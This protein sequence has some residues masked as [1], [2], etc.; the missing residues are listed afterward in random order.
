MGVIDAILE[1][2]QQQPVK[3]RH[4]AQRI[5]DRLRAEHGFTGGY[6]IVKD[7]IRLCRQRSQ[8]VFIPLTHAPGSA[9]VD[10]GQALVIVAGEECTAHFFALDLPHSDAI[11]VM[12]FPAEST[13][14]FLE[15]HIRAFAYL[16]GA[17]GSILSIS[18]A[19]KMRAKRSNRQ[20]STESNWRL[21]ASF[22]SRS[23]AGLRSFAPETPLSLYST[24][25]KPRR[26]A[27]SCNATACVSI[28]C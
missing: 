1:E 2:D 18:V 3:Q 4:T 7:Y 13:E 20:T 26:S 15:G 16:G 11:F 28:V 17:P 14:A 19:R 24:T 8:E 12:A 25:S 5:F 27:Y 10:F 6:T 9:Q 23:S 22:I 21:R